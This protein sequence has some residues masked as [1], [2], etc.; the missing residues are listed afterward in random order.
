M[1]KHKFGNQLLRLGVL[2]MMLCCSFLVNAQ[3][4]QVTGVV[5]DESGEP[6]V[7]VNVLQQGTTN[8]TI[9]DIDG[10]F[11]LNVGSGSK[12][13]H[14]TYVGFV[15]EV[16][17]VSNQRTLKVVLKEDKQNL[18]EVVVIGYG[19]AKKKD[20]TGAVA[21]VRTEKLESQAPRTV[22]D[23]LRGQAAGLTIAQSNTAKGDASLMVRGNNTLKAGNSPLIVL[24]GV[25]YEGAI[26]DINPMDIQSID[27]LKD[28]S[29][30]AVYGAK[31][32]NGVVA[33]VTRKGGQGGKPAINFTQ[34]LVSL[35]LH[36]CRTFSMVQVS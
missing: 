7:G 18:E 28:A 3:N 10:K 16:V 22:Q 5:V 30:A 25:I 15:E 24:D 9:T 36:T 29:S 21:S 14:F 19:T 17:N 1:E 6:L 27:I 20:L 35:L 23:L 12:L 31:A 13:L 11:T 4:T 8:G 34:T 33:I 26:T 2:L 32:A